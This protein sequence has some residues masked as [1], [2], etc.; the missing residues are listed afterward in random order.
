MMPRTTEDRSPGIDPRVDLAR[1]AQLKQREDAAFLEAR[2]RSLALLERARRSMPLGVPMSW[3]DFLF[4]H[5]PMFVDT[6]EGAYFTD[7]DG[8]RYL[9]MY[10]NITVAS[11]GHTH[12]AVVAAVGERLRRGV[13]FGLPTEDAIVVSET[14]A[15][16]WGLPKWQFA[17]SSTQSNTDAIRLARI[18]TGRERVLTFEGKYHGHLGELLAIEGD[19]GT[20][21]EYVGIT[22][23]DITRTVVVDWN[24]LEA[25]ERA[26]RT[27]EIALLIAEPALTN[28]GIVFPTPTF[29]AELRR[30][31]RETGTLLLV[32]ETQT[33]P[34]AYGGLV[35]EWGLD[36]DFVVLGKSL[37]GGVPTSAYGMTED[38][39]G[40]IDRESE[41]YEVSGGA[42]DEPAIGGTMFGN[43][44]S[45]AATRAALTEV[46]TPEN[47]EWTLRLAGRLVQGMRAVFDDA[48][49]DWDVYQLGN[50]A[51]FRFSPEP[52]RNNIEAGERDIPAVRHLQRVYMANRGIWEFGWWCGPVVSTQATDDDIDLYLRVFSGFVREL[53]A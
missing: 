31:T 10:L 43:A 16:R 53:L 8:H 3:M 48:G 26:L 12:P 27:G 34:C 46:W 47:H 6:A 15:E 37:G 25:V 28:S 23:A 29:H 52:P 50:R 13:Q 18:A 7:V 39:A 4:D 36:P 5:P 45:M 41:P 33:L 2:P 51:G 32:D 35:R 42:V 44:L 21:P 17:L 1:V 14:L 9:D 49:V 11:A 19:D 24:D 22:D 30:L 20:V 40:L 38:I